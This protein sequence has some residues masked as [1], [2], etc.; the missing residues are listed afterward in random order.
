MSSRTSNEPKFVSGVHA[1]V[2]NQSS[3]HEFA[4]VMNQFTQRGIEEGY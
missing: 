3:C 1:Q 4:Q 2:M